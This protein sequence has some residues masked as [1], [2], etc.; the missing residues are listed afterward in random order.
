[1]YIS[2]KISELQGVC[3]GWTSEL[4]FVKA[5]ITRFSRYAV[6]CR[7]KDYKLPKEDSEECSELTISVPDFPGFCLSI[8]G[9]SF[10]SS[11]D[12]VIKVKA[13]YN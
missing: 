4:P 3:S 5:K 8:P 6:F 13:Q 11:M 9:T 12:L 1:M 2:E 10:P 7:L